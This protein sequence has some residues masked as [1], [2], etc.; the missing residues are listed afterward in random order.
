MDFTFGIIT[1]GNSDANIQKVIDSIRLQNI[2]KYEI[3]IMGRSDIS[4]ND[5]ISIP[6]DESIKTAWITKKKNLIAQLAKYENVVLLHDYVVL[7]KGWYEGFLRFGNSFKICMNRILTTDGRR[8]RD[9]VIFKECL[10]QI[11]TL[12]PYGCNLTPAISKLT[13]ISGTYYIIK[14]KTALEYPLDERLVL[15]QGEDVILCQTLSKNNILLECNPFS[16]VSILKEKDSDKFWEN[17]MSSEFYSEFSKW[18]EIYS[19]EVFKY[20]CKFQEDWITSIV[21]S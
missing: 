19:E 1:G 21:H 20:Q 4:G 10:P 17:E 15:F 7:S 12:L 3:I 8:Y 11:N 9:H 16:T 5:I 6:F 2:P 13:Y 18:A 14:K